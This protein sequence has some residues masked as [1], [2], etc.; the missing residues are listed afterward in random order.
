MNSTVTKRLV[1]RLSYR[2]EIWQGLGTARLLPKRLLI[3]R[4]NGQIV[5]HTS[6]LRDFTRRVVWPDDAKWR[7]DFFFVNAIWRHDF[8]FV[9]I[10]SGNGLSPVRRQAIAW[11]MLTYYQL[12]LSEQIL[13]FFRSKFKTFLSRKCLSKCRLQNVGHCV[14]S[15][16][17]GHDQEGCEWRFTWRSRNSRNRVYLRFTRSK[18]SCYRHK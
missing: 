13:M 16:D 8:S 17:R 3:F 14:P 15:V 2:A 4:A 1:L 7:H 12:D 9:N 11:P 5:N 10:G 18:L 6:R